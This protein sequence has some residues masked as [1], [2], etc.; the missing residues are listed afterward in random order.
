MLTISSSS[1]NPAQVEGKAR[2][3]KGLS[4]T[5][6]GAFN[7]EERRRAGALRFC[8]RYFLWANISNTSHGPVYSPL[9]FTETSVEEGAKP[10]IP[11]PC[12]AV[13]TMVMVFKV[14]VESVVTF[15][16]RV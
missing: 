12:E 6:N 10:L 11:A 5:P 16:C 2:K 9:D 13:A 1:E 15:H 8:S 3:P 7:A 4:A 14:P